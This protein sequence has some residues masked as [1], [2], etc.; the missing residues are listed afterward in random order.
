MSVS[1]APRATQGSDAESAA[2]S[3]AVEQPT[4][5]TARRRHPRPGEPARALAMVLGLTAGLSL[6]L[7]LFVSIAVNSGPNGVR[8]AV[9][10]PAPAVQQITA[11]L[12]Q[13]GGP[14]A[15]DV[16]VVN[17][18][19]AARAALVERTADG[20]IVIGRNGPT[21]FTA[22]AGS[23]AIAQAL[24]AAAGELSGAPGAGTAVVDV[25]PVPEG[26]VHGV[27][28]AAGS[29]PMIIA[30]LVLGAAAALSLR[31][32]WTV[33]VTVVGGAV[34]IGLSLAGVLAWLGVSGGN[35]LAEASA[36]TLAVAAS[37]LVVAGLARLM[38]V[39]GVGIGA[40]LLVIVGNP[41][42]GIPTSPRLLPGP[43]GEFGQ[44]LPTGAG[45]TLLRT[46]AYFPEA[47]VAFPVWVLLGW[48]V[49]GAGAVL[50]GQ[51]RGR[52]ALETHAN[53][54]GRHEVVTV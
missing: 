37:G 51:H 39:P 42:S 44:W 28:L 35:Y 16:T 27:G 36:I 3:A 34:A 31:G 23:P 22:S 52:S 49:L 14:D 24:N 46:A 47:S 11:A 32:R 2:G 45:G 10:G 1:D 15:F 40:L 41:L 33:L 4:S 48:A 5:A 7:A 9:A 21:V 20:A 38:G 12:T 17:D 26:D 29:F 50:I 6:I 53:S 13:A 25:V 19:A 43:W 18:E 54:A 30:G 8:L